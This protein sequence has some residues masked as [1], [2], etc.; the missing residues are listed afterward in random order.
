MLFML[1]TNKPPP[2]PYYHFKGIIHALTT[3]TIIK[4]VY[5]HFW[6]G[7]IECES[8]LD[9]ISDVKESEADPL[10]STGMEDLGSSQ[11]KTTRIK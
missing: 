5:K 11:Q 8:D 2:P 6:R 9:V 7:Q 10:S 4:L 1:F 3:L